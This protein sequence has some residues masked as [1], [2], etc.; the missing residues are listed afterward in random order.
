MQ[1]LEAVQ[2]QQLSTTSLAD[3]LLINGTDVT[4]DKMNYYKAL[5]F[6]Q[7]EVLTKKEISGSITPEEAQKKHLYHI[8]LQVIHL[9]C[10]LLSSEESTP[11]E[12]VWKGVLKFSESGEW[13][14]EYCVIEE[15]AI[16]ITSDSSKNIYFENITSIRV[17]STDDSKF[18]ILHSKDDVHKMSM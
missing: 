3:T 13:V 5:L 10:S 11:E 14:S 1:L 8:L 6:N 4:A 17:F 12:S 2:P 18:A 9:N 15:K 16:C 7:N